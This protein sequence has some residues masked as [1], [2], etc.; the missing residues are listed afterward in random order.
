MSGMVTEYSIWS[1][2]IENVWTG[3]QRYRF[4]NGK[5]QQSTSH[6]FL[7]PLEDEKGICFVLKWSVLFLLDLKG[8]IVSDPM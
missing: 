3:T 4:C 1:R 8:K 6:T 7:D 2:N 5:I